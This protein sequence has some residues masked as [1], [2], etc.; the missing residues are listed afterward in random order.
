MKYSYWKLNTPITERDHVD[1]EMNS[2]LMLHTQCAISYSLQQLGAGDEI[3]W[4]TKECRFRKLGG[5]PPKTDRV[6]PVSGSVVVDAGAPV[7]EERRWRTVYYDWGKAEYLGKF[8]DLWR[9]TLVQLSHLRL[10]S[11]RW[12]AR[13]LNKLHVSYTKSTLDRALQTRTRK[14]WKH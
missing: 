8:I 2:L 1:N 7:K 5:N 12:N 14:Q 13:D 3:R 10:S 9:V 4:R 11:L 6:G